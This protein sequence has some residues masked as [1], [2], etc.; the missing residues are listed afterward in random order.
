MAP[1]RSKSLLKLSRPDLKLMVEIITGHNNFISFSTKIKKLD[2]TQCRFCNFEPETIMHLIT[3]CTKFTID[4]LELKI[5][6]YDP[7][8]ST[9]ESLSWSIPL[10]LRFFKLPPLY[11]ILVQ[12]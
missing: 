10:T 9:T 8:N 6:R 12:T 7:E 2:N 4:R 3:K 1:K 5:M 11:N